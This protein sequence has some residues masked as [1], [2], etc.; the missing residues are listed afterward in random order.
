[1]ADFGHPLADPADRNGDD[2]AIDGRLPAYFFASSLPVK[3]PTHRLSC[4]R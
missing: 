1:M 3:F 4:R 2:P